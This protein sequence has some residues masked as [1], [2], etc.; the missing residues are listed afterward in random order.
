M[1]AVARSDVECAPNQAFVLSG[2]DGSTL[3]DAVASVETGRP[4]PAIAPDALAKR[5]AE[6]VG[7]ASLKTPQPKDVVVHI[8]PAWPSAGSSHVF[9]CQ[10]EWLEK[11]G[12]PAICIHLDTDDLEW[13][14]RLGRVPEELANLPG[15]QALHRWFLSRSREERQA[16]EGA[17]IPPPYSHLSLEGEERIARHVRIPDSLIAFLRHRTV[18]FVL[19]NYGHNWPLIE[20]LGLER[21]PVAVET[22]D[23]RPIQHALYNA[24]P[25]VESA[26]DV[27]LAMFARSTCAVFINENERAAFQRRYPSNAAMS[28][29]PFLDVFPPE[30][31]R[32]RFET[33]ATA[34]L[35]LTQLPLNIVLDLFRPRQ[36]RRRRFALFVGSNHAANVES[37]RWFLLGAYP[38][39][40]ID[41]DLVIMIA[42]GIAEAFASANLPNVHF[43]G[44]VSDLASLYAAADVLLLP[45]TA[46]TGLPI[47]TLD[48]LTARV[49]FVGTSKAVDAIPGLKD[50]VGAYDDGREFAER[51]RAIAFDDAAGT[52]FVGKINSYCAANANQSCYQDA[53]DGVLTTMNV[54]TAPSLH[55]PAAR[56]LDRRVA[57]PAGRL[58]QRYYFWEGHGLEELIGA[59]S[60]AEGIELTAA[61]ARIGLAWLSPLSLDSVPPKHVELTGQIA[62]ALSTQVLVTVQGTFRFKLTLRPGMTEHFAFRAPLAS[63]QRTSRL[64]L[65]FRLEF[66]SAV[67]PQVVTVQRLSVA[68]MS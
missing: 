67:E 18:R 68:Y 26:L 20:R 27:E 7:E 50:L 6:I 43:C 16:E 9:R 39:G 54:K 59:H 66:D 10:L 12:V 40:L 46:G 15:G 52:A 38:Q 35:S 33:E 57:Q 62:A 29:F 64:S 36:E 28:A 1:F 5:L 32:S 2:H 30:P 61:Y 63:P 22:H 23:I 53:W 11:R 8:A 24:A 56:A 41:A 37:L 14:D 45:V 17:A 55:A 51:V 13:N 65:E 44:R 3:A 47:K 58:D 48:A 49:P 31:A 19:L 25:V 42:G 21:C 34:L 4:L 60:G